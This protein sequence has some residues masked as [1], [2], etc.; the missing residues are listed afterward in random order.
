MNKKQWNVV[1]WTSAVMSVYFY[2]WGIMDDI[3]VLKYSQATFSDVA[4]AGE[5]PKYIAILLFGLAI[6]CFMCKNRIDGGKKKNG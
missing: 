2:V 6:I 1:G 3:V 5:F 4:M